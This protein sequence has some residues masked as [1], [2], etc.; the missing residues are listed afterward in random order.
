MRRTFG[1]GAGVLVACVVAAPAAA[2]QLAVA[3][4][5]R[6]GLSGRLHVQF[7]TTSVDSAAGAP[8]PA[9]EFIIRR[10]RLTFDVTLNEL[11]SARL[12]PDYSTGNGAGRFSL[13][14]AYIRLTFGPGLRATVG[15]FKRPFDLFQLASTTQLVVAE[16]GGQVRGVRACGALPVV[17]SYSNLAVGLAYADRD[18]GVMLDGDAVPRRL[19]YAVAV[20]NGE[21]AFT[22]ESTSGKQV[23]ARVSTTPLPGVTIAAN[24]TFKD[25]RHPTDGRPA[26]AVGW[27]ADVELGDYDGGPH[28]QAAVIGGD[29]WQVARLA[30]GDTTDVA[31][32]LSGQVIASLRQPVRGRWISG[33]EP[34]ARA[35]WADP[36]RSLARDDGWLLTPGVIV[37][38][39]D[40]N[41]LF[42]NLD[43]WLP[44]AGDTEYALLL[45]LS[46]NF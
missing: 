8:I 10:A 25:Y 46:V 19:Q 40:R 7:S 28:L 36:N 22:L 35:S 37:H 38:L 26:H 17:C 14:D 6:V 29:N 1:A 27:G 34:L 44:Q 41:M 33:L 3:D 9:S 4:D 24:G 45:Q 23:T 39:R 42:V 5:L 30:P 12:Q 20:T 13:R 11:L 16:R 43:L 2:Q 18:L 15:H 31:P 32:F 21:P